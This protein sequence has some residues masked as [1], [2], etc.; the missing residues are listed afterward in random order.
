MSQL[1]APLLKN[2]GSGTRFFLGAGIFGT[3]KFMK[4][5]DSEDSSL[6]S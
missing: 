4:W 2:P 1:G 5:I 3:N 6:L